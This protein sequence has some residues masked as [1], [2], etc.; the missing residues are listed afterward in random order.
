MLTELQNNEAVLLMYV[1][2]ELPADDRAEVEDM[3]GRDETLRA[4]LAAMRQT[5]VAIDA[6]MAQADAGLRVPSPF[7]AARALGD[8]VRRRMRPPG[9]KSVDER[10][11][12]S[13]RRMRMV[14]Y[15]LTAAAAIAL[16]MALWWKSAKDEITA[17][18]AEAQQQQDSFNSIAGA[19]QDGW[20]R[21]RSR[22]TGNWNDS[23]L[24]IRQVAA[25]WDSSLNSDLEE[26]ELHVSALDYL[27]KSD[28]L[29]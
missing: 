9:R 5:Y 6:A 24:D 10:E 7:S 25:M 12:A 21:Q 1:A 14:L 26:A 27:N 17:P 22:R 16:G 20:G 19:D 11:D 15:P 8:E 18:L 29:Q 23:E 13:R 4:Q 3:L 2:N 28:A